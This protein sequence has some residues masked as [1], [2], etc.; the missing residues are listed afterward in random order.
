MTH[1]NDNTVSTYPFISG[2]LFLLISDWHVT[3]P[4]PVKNLNK[5]IKPIKYDEVKENDIIFIKR[6]Y[7]DFFFKTHLPNINTKV[8]II[9]HNG[10]NPIKDE[11]AKYIND[12][13]VSFWCVNN[14]TNHSKVNTLPIG[15]QNK[16]LY[17]EGNPQ[18]DNVIL[19][20]IRRKKIDK[21]NDVLLTFN[22]NT[23]ISHRKPVYE[24]FEDK[25]FITERKYTNEDR[26]DGRGS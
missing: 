15:I 8:I 17:F 10:D 2:N 14:L 3:P 5:Y 1:L 24:Y 18:G 25:K 12:K 7:V 16:N 9:T 19:N 4:Y 11:H 23:N 6:D 26:K 13:V 22:I 20:E 21:I